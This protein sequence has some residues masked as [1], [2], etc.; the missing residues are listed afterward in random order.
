MGK[1]HARRCAAV[2]SSQ[3]QTTSGLSRGG[4]QPVGSVGLKMLFGPDNVVEIKH[5]AK[6]KWVEKER[7][8]DRKKIVNKNLSCCSLNKKANF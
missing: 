6:I 2:A 7:F 4:R 1:E 3:S 5:D 8:L